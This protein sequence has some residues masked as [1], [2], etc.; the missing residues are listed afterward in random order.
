MQDL[1]CPFSSTLLSDNFGC[2]HASQIVRRGG[3]EIACSAAASHDR[4]T[5][6]FRKLKDA[7]LPAFAVEDDLLQMP[8]SVLVKI[9]YGGLLGLQ[10]SIAR[11]DTRKDVIEDINALIDA[12]IEHYSALENIPCNTLVD[13]MTAYKLSRRGKRNR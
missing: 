3:A 12:A 6:L 11:E 7:A 8:H 4:C 13:D 1:I 9:Q 2:R 5:L 10:R